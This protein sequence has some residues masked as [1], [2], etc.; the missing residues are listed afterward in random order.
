MNSAV[1]TRPSLIGN[2]F[3]SWGAF[4][5]VAAIGFFLSPI[6]V[7]SLG[8]TSYGVWSL[9]VTV[10]G[11]LGLLD[12]GVR[13]AVTRYIAHHHA[14]ADH[15][16][17]SLIATAAIV[18]FGA[19][20]VLA[21]LISC[22]LSWLAP[23]AFHIPAELLPEAQTVLVLGGFTIASTLLGAVFGGVVTGLERFDISAGVEIL[24]TTVR[25]AAVL[26]A[27]KLGYGLVALAWIHLAGAILYGLAMWLIVR[28][29]LPG[30]RFR[31]R[32]K[33]APHVR[34]ILS[35]SAYLSALHMLGVVIYYTDAL[36]IATMLPIGAVG[37][38]VIAGNLTTYA[39]QVSSALS[40]MFT[41]RISAMY[42]A[43]SDQ[44]VSTVLSASRAA[45]LVIPPIA[46]TFLLRGKSFIGLWMGP[47]YGT[48]SGEV[49]QVLALVVWCGS[50]RAV[51]GAAIIGVNMH[52]RLVPLA[53][54]EALCNIALSLA[55]ARP[56]G[57]VGV[58]IGTLIPALIVSFLLVP[59]QMQQVIGVPA[60]D[61]IVN[62][63]VLPTVSA[64]PFAAGTILLERY[65][66]STSVL[67]FFVQVAAVLPLAFIGAYAVCLN[68]QERQ[69]LLAALS[70][71]GIRI[72]G[73]RP[74][75]AP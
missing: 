39:R 43:G 42:S 51:A 13:G 17:S 58:A 41:P 29:I 40:K 7:N 50:A 32:E 26:A 31:F 34:T 74:Q 36:V 3:A 65:F 27:L 15:E 38:Y 67:M 66:P 18:L 59:R 64:L 70:K 49:L 63:V 1:R 44:I 68:A 47:E 62:A 20:G 5:Y 4:L 24:L 35:F 55:L 72:P 30:L 48:P 53:A 2:A 22:G 28:R 21:I 14:A 25:S 75:R 12:F 16:S 45:T 33:L 69:A 8:T 6:V 37:I 46:I 9:L 57:V 54:F 19:M 60:R 73:S 10:V 23:V 11:Y 71:R 61:Y 52:R 56:L